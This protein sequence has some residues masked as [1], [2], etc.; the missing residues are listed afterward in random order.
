[1]QLSDNKR[2]RDSNIEFHNRFLRITGNANRIPESNGQQISKITK[3]VRVSRRHI[4]SHE[5]NIKES[6]SSSN[7]SIRK[8]R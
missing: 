2:K 4:S 8:I 1:M 5:Q 3:H 7:K 6:L